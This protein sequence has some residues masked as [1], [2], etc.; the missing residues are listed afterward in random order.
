MLRCFGITQIQ[1]T[2]IFVKK[3]IFWTKVTK[4]N[5]TFPKIYQFEV[6]WQLLRKS[7][8]FWF[9]H[10]VQKNCDIS[11]TYLLQMFNN[12]KISKYELAKAKVDNLMYNMSNCKRVSFVMNYKHWITSLPIPRFSIVLNHSLI[13]E[14]KILYCCQE[15]MMISWLEENKWSTSSLIFLKRFVV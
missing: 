7:K 9:L 4:Y 2:A 14:S 1:N 13:Q 15:V 11:C 5:A 10:F 3:C 12:R 8:Q 6:Y